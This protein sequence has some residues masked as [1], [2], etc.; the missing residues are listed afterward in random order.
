[1]EEKHE[2][3][4]NYRNIIKIEL[5]YDVIL[6]DL[7][8][9]YDYAFYIYHNKSKIEADIPCEI[10]NV[11][12]ESLDK[13]VYKEID[14]IITAYNVMYVEFELDIDI[15]RHSILSKIEEISLLE[16][17][18]KSKVI[19]MLCNEFEYDYVL[20]YASICGGYF[21]IKEDSAWFDWC[22]NA[23]KLY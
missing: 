2:S 7:D 9:D 4:L 17:K 21:T 22:S 23:N 14:D 18:I 8:K 6:E 20:P 15:Q 11:L 3:I 10:L 12:I 19:Q 1:M 16:G 13:I 5:R